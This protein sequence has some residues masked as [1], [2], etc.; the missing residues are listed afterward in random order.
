MTSFLENSEA[1][2]KLDEA[3]SKLLLKSLF[4]LEKKRKKSGVKF[5]F[6]SLSSS[7]LHF[8]NVRT[9]CVRM[10]LLCFVVVEF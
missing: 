10:N 2:I 7:Y 8:R 3:R 1:Q 9:K 5:K 6:E 4:E